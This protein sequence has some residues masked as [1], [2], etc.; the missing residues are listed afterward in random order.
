MRPLHGL[1]KQGNEHPVT[2]YNI[3]EEKSSIAP[4][5]KH[6]NLQEE[7]PFPCFHSEQKCTT[8]LILVIYAVRIY[9]HR[10]Q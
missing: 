7:I 1:E 10:N 2:K 3:P 9:P 8:H 4:L 5:Q 6:Q